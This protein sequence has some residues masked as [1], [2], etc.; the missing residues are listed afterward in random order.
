MLP[1]RIWKICDSAGR[2]KKQT[3]SYNLSKKKKATLTKTLEWSPGKRIKCPKDLHLLERMGQLG[4]TLV[5]GHQVQDQP[6]EA[7]S[8]EPQGV[9][10]IG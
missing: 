9:I 5:V 7:A 1:E 4:W 10:R 2:I 8:E 3:L 6:L